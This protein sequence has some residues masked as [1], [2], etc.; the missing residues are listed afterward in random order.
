M[1]YGKDHHVVGIDFLSE[2]SELTLLDKYTKQLQEAEVNGIV[3][4]CDMIGGIP[5]KT[6]T[7]LLNDYENTCVVTGISSSALLEIFFII[8]D[9]S[10]KEVGLFLSN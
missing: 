3:S 6:A 2:D 9:E 1:I 5:C 10:S 7:M 4:I 8:K